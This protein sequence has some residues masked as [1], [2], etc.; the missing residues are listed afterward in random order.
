MDTNT[1]IGLAMNTI[2]IT[3]RDTNR[4]LGMVDKRYI[5]TV[6][7]IIH[8]LGAIIA[9]V[10]GNIVYL[11]RVLLGSQALTSIA[12][13]A[14]HS[15]NFAA[16]LTTALFFWNKV[17]SWQ[18]STTTMEEKGLTKRIVQRFNQGR[19][20]ATML[21]YSLIPFLYSIL[22]ND[23][24]QS[25]TFSNSIALTMIL[26]S[27]YCYR[28]IRDYGAHLWLVYGMTPMA[29]GI[30]LGLYSEQSLFSFY[31]TYPL[32]ID[33]FQK[34]ASLVISCVQLGFLMYYL[35]SR[36]LVT[37]RTVQKTCK[38]Y[39]MTML[40]VYVMRVQHDLL[41]YAF[42]TSSS[43]IPWP[44]LVQPMLLSLVFWYKFTKLLWPRTNENS[45]TTPT[46]PTKPKVH[47]TPT[48]GGKTKRRSSLRARIETTIR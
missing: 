44:L 15:C 21:L 16:S 1:K 10:L 5:R 2:S 38:S 43:T 35:Y 6:P 42:G 7:G 19:G 29:L 8:G 13:T 39:H 31:E 33:R 22:P 3:K 48:I 40:V 36:D 25:K 18:L 26:G 12:H 28:L 34:E 14:F 11:N 9:L 4:F 23:C 17:Q 24:L 27:A 46:A 47:Q 37:K 32:A 45:A 20:I 41:D 30:S